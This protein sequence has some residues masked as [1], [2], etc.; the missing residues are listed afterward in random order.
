MNRNSSLVLLFA[1]LFF[2]HFF[3]MNFNLGNGFE[4]KGVH[5]QLLPLF[6]FASHISNHTS[7]T[8]VI[9]GYILFLIFLIAN[10]NKA[11]ITSPTSILFTII[12]CSLS[13]LFELYSFICDYTHKYSGE[14]SRFGLILFVLCLGIYNSKKPVTNQSLK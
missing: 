3:I 4:F 8:S 14:N 11:K 1:G 9:I 5:L 10:F 12:F 6:A 7:L 13:V 2:S